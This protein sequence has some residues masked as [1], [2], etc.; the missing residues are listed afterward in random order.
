MSPLQAIVVAVRLF[1][2]WL[3]LA[4]FA[5]VPLVLSYVQTVSLPWP[6]R[7]VMWSPVIAMTAAAL[8]LWLF[9]VSVA[10][11]LLPGLPGPDPT[12]KTSADEWFLVGSRLMG[13]WV[14]CRSAP[15][16]LFQIVYLYQS[17]ARDA[18][19]LADPPT[20][21]TAAHLMIPPQVPG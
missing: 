13:L 6:Q 16:L 8:Y 10:R 9:P 17:T 12:T 18:E 21:L 3:G 4:L 1:A 20:R 5:M 15:T 2:I 14:L 7:A 11:K 19:R